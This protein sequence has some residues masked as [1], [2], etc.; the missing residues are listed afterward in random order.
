M[1]NLLAS[2]HVLVDGANLRGS[3]PGTGW[4]R[5]DAR[6]LRQWA[7]AYGH[8]TVDWFQGSY[9][10]TAGFFSHLRAAGIRVHTRTPKLFADGRRK[11]DMDLDLALAA[12]D[13]AGRFDTVVLISGDGDFGPLVARLVER[14]VRVVVVA[15]RR[16]LGPELLEHL[17]DPDDDFVELEQALESFGQRR[18]SAA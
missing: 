4:D 8:P 14:G 9:P 11:A 15:T 6:R 3:L 7:G 17:D 13:D 5:I 1:S 18:P 10:G 2:V 16:C 12:V